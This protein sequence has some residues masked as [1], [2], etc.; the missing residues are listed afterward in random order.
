M[1]L[2]QAYGSLVNLHELHLVFMLIL[3]VV[4]Y[5][6]VTISVKWL[7]EKAA[8]CF[9]SVKTLTGKII[10]EM[11]CHVSMKMLC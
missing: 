5:S 7:V 10:S 2:N 1:F 11:T 3:V 9:A 4:M 6:F 8:G